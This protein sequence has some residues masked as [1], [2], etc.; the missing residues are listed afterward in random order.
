MKNSLL[1]VLILASIA[2]LSIIGI[3]GIAAVRGAN[4]IN[5][6]IADINADYQR[7]ERSLEG[8]RA[9]LDTVRISVRDYMLDPFAEPAEV[10][11]EQFRMLKDSIDR[12]LY[13][14]SM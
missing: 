9:D 8:L 5:D 2:L 13:E 7:T 11:R 1:F 6:E 12:R 3:T 14:L 4:R 10:K